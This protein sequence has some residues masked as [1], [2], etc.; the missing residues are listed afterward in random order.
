LELH[1]APGHLL[2]LGL[3]FQQGLADIYAGSNPQSNRQ[4]ALTAGYFFDFN[5]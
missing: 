2:T 3:Q 1:A 5:P 4:Y